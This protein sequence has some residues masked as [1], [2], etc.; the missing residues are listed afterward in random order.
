MKKILAFLI[1]SFIGLSQSFAA[2][3]DIVP[4]MVG[5]DR[6]AYGCIGSAGYSW[7]MNLKRC[8]RPWEISAT[9]ATV[10]NDS[11]S[12]LQAEGSICKVATDGCNTIQIQDGKLGASTKMFCA[13]TT[14]QWSCLDMSLENRRVGFLSTNDRNQYFTFQNHLGQKTSDK[15]ETIISNFGDRVLSAN[16]YDVA[17]SR[18]VLDVA[19]ARFDAAIG[20]ITMNTPADSQM[21]QKDTQTYYILSVART[22]LEILQ[23]RWA[24]NSAQ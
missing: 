7:D 1:L 14:E 6:D 4:T 24:Q 17:K 16:G 2:T 21:S 3:V 5:N 9:G 22:E 10:Y 12:F 8:I 23:N 13:D 18:A 15:I 20:K 19:I 11:A